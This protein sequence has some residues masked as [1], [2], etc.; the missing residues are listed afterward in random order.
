MN[1][2][3]ALAALVAAVLA[4]IVPA[5]SGDNRIDATEW[6]NVAILTLGAAAV[7][8][9]P[10]V[11]GARYTKVVLAVLTAAATAAASLISDGISLTDW[12]QLAL[13]ALGALGVYQLPYSPNPEP[14]VTP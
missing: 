11:P 9:A 6:V 2:S 1:Y 14:S 13:A 10:N 5:L 8:A 3:K 7:F 12:L 4:A